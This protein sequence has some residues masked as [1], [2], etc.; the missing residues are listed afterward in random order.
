MAWA[1]CRVYFSPGSLLHGLLSSLCWPCQRGSPGGR[2]QPSSGVP[3]AGG[4]L[5]SAAPGASPL[6]PGRHIF[7]HPR[8]C[9]STGWGRLT[10]AEDLEPRVAPAARRLQSCPK[11]SLE[12]CW[13]PPVSL[14][15]SPW[16]TLPSRS[17]STHTSACTST[18]S[19]RPSSS[20]DQANLLCPYV[21]D[22]DD[23]FTVQGWAWGHLEVTTLLVPSRC[24]GHTICF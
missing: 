10:D 20:T 15:P 1:P 2:A 24:P 3:K 16:G 13:C 5:T 7:L 6:L 23:A 21:R 14:L 18:H 22:G 12:S 9:C 4:C 11:P 19:E 17:P 8:P